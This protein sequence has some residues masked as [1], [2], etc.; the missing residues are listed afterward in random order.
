MTKVMARAY[1]L[2]M[3]GLAASIG[4]GATTIHAQQT[5]LD[6]LLRDAD[7]L[8]W[9]IR[10]ARRAGDVAVARVPTAGA[11]PDPMLGAGIMNFPISSP[12]LGNDMMTMTRIELGL[13]LPWPGKVGIREDRAGLEA[14]A[15]GF[16]V[17]WAR[18][19]V[20][21][22]VAQSYYRLYFI[23][24]ALDVAGRNRDLM[25]AVAR[26]SATRYAV[27]ASSSE[28]V[29]RPQT[30]YAR[31]G[32]QILTLEAERV[33]EVAR[34]NSL[35]SRPIG[36][37]V[38]AV[39]MPDR[40]VRAVAPP[41]SD[42]RPLSS[43]TADAAVPSAHPPRDPLR[44]ADLQAIAVESSPIVQAHRRRVGAQERAVALA[45]RE[46]LPDFDVSAGYAYRA[47]PGDFFDLMISAPVPIFAGRKQSQNVVAERAALAQQHARHEAMLA[48]VNAEVACFAT[49]ASRLRAR[50]ALLA[51]SILPQSRAALASAT[52]S[53]EVGRSG[54]PTVLEA[55]IVLN[56]DELD[57]HRLLAD[58]AMTVAALERAV[59]AEV[60]P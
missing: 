36:S 40:I 29:L 50:L 38:S 59:G 37:P 53:Y 8:N 54:L 20:A 12:G 51:G 1:L 16:D 18:R 13:T 32:E 52:I 31:L 33:A 46:T 15:A 60:L 6:A 55:Q 14:A 34:I 21:A 41:N 23:D 5:D 24:Q 10:A 11:L 35:L 30:E 26:L 7:T 56:R 17:E 4:A 9:E 28:D 58:F 45:E 42:E 43:D 2:A 49:E 25:E 3:T 39:A 22:R 19:D 27:G 44:V 47:G 57:Y 48:D